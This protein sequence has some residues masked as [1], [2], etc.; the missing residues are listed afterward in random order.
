MSD[1]VD[2]YGVKQ[3]HEL[4]PLNK[5]G[6]KEELLI[7]NSKMEKYLSK[8]IDCKLYERIKLAMKDEFF[9]KGR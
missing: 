2:I 7:D 3:I 1:V 4:T 9:Q 8:K 6:G 5:L